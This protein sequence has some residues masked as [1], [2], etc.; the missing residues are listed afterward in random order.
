MTTRGLGLIGV[1]IVLAG[2]TL[3]VIVANRHDDR[4]HRAGPPAAPAHGC[5]RACLAASQCGLALTTCARDCATNPAL[6][7]CFEL[8]ATS[9][10]QAA[11]CGMGITCAGVVP[12]GTGTCKLAATC[13]LGCSP[14][15]FACGCRCAVSMSPQ[16]VLVLAQLDTC[17]INCGYDELCMRGSCGGIALACLNR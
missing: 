10:T 12:T 17:A 8:A 13:Q 6:R 14:G 5:E 3:L 1:A 9:C 4:E 7:T 15:D 2:V 16:H 11:S